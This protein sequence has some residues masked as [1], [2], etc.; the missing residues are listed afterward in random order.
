MFIHDRLAL[1]LN[2]CLEEANIPEWV[3]KENHPD[4]KRP[5]KGQPLITYLLMMWKYKQQKLWRFTF[6]PRTLLHRTQRMPQ[7]NKRNWWSK[8]HWST[9]PQREQNQE[10][11]EAMRWINYKKA[12][13]YG[14]TKLNNWLFQNEQNI[15][16]NH[17]EKPYSGID[18]KKNMFS[19]SENRDWCLLGSCSITITIY[20]RNDAIQSNT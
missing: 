6:K 8:I 5:K 12:Y 9:H 1:E 7:D 11:N 19:W 14:P 4:R 2:K 13:L 20:N 15:R 18:S 16:Q 3:T 10:K 17:K